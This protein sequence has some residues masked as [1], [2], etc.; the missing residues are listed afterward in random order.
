MGSAR[1]GQVQVVEVEDGLV[2]RVADEP[3]PGQGGEVRAAVRQ[4]VKAARRLA[5]QGD[6]QV[7]RPGGSLADG[8]A[9]AVADPD[10]G[11]DRHHG[12]VPDEQL[13]ALDREHWPRFVRPRG[14]VAPLVDHIGARLG[15]QGEVQRR[16]ALGVVEGANG[17]QGGSTQLP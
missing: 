10:A 6:G 13:P 3:D 16:H 5:G 15:A 9:D 12:V 1:I 8:R 11:R 4:G 17:S 14:P 2:G 7:P